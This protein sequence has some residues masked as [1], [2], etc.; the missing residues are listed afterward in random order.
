VRNR[1]DSIKIG[2]ELENYKNL[3][4]MCYFL[5]E[6]K[7]NKL[8]IINNS[9]KVHTNYLKEDEIKE[10]FEISLNHNSIKQYQKGPMNDLKLINWMASYVN[11]VKGNSEKF[12]KSYNGQKMLFLI[13]NLNPN[14]K[15]LYLVT[16][17]YKLLKGKQ[18]F[19]E[20][21]FISIMIILLGLF[22]SKLISNNLSKPLKSLELYTEK[23]AK[24]EWSTP[25]NVERED[26]IGR[27]ISSMNKMQQSLKNA[28]EEQQ[29]F[30]QSISHDLKTP[31]MVIK[32]YAE[33]ILDD[34]YIENLEETAKIISGEASK[35]E[36][37]IKQL[38]YF[39]SLNYI[40]ENEKINS[41]V[42][43]DLLFKDLYERLKLIR[44]DVS[45][46]LNLEQMILKCNK[47][48]ITVA[49]ENILDNQLRYAKSKISI[50]L[51]KIQNQITIEIFND[52]PNIKEENLNKIF[53]KFYKEKKGNFGLG[54]AISQKIIEF[55]NGN[56][57]AV[58]NSKGVYFIIKI[59]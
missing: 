29:A 27:L 14:G 28:D 15:S 51:Y 33:S 20:I 23:I 57:H 24:K 48:K 32:S 35:L 53:D 10:H 41:D 47:D 22:V 37:K 38:I 34:I 7:G 8:K 26:E 55:Y 18:D 1:Y 50:K 11:E 6:K 56:I 42:R 43:I 52:G 16:Y 21:T 59:E 12:D 9:P 36:H 4:D 5:V 25:L 58:N 45:W 44:S 17:S 40:M 54:L 39:N 30:L 2:E 31:V 13:Q 46:E 49:F 3:N 19:S